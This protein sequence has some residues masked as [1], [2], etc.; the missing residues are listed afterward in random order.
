MIIQVLKDE[1]HEWYQMYNRDYTINVID[2]WKDVSHT[3]PVVCS[4][5]L[6]REHVRYWLTFNQ[7]AVYV[8]RGYL[9]N[10]LHKQRKFW[11]YSVNDWANIQL[12]PIPYSRWDT[13]GLPR[14]PWKVTNIQRVLIA[15]SKMTSKVWTPELSHNWAV[16]MLD[17]FPGAEVRIRP[18]DQTPGLRWESLW[19]DFDW[20]DLVVSQSSAITVEA[21]WYGKKVISLEPCPTWA[22]KKFTLDDW[23]DPAEPELRNDWH[24]HI[25]WCQYTTDEILSGNVLD[26][27]QKYT[28]NII[29]Y[30]SNHTYN[31]FNRCQ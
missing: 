29:E 13:M 4:G 20:A 25:A 30:K 17:K 28:G 22:A 9:G 27:L 1:L 19:N 11:R 18:K 15:P 12:R 7:P 24:E 16:S 2:N 14:H 26:L 5:N 6:L 8:A 21:F 23:Q 31:L 3:S 10:H